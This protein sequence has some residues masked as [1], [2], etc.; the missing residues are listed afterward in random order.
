MFFSTTE[1]T[2]RKH[3]R[4]VVWDTTPT[5]NKS[6]CRNR[7]EHV[8]SKT[9]MLENSFGIPVQKLRASLNEIEQI[10]GMYVFFLCI[11]NRISEY[12]YFFF[13]LIQ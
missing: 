3:R 6:K 4:T 5:K 7:V 11:K 9:T 13:F 8:D 10:G 12:F 1:E 2:S